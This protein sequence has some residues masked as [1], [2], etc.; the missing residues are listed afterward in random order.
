VYYEPL[1]LLGQ[2]D[3]GVMQMV[4][5]WKERNIAQSNHSMMMEALT[6]N[7]RDQLFDIMTS[8]DRKQFGLPT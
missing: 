2:V 3:G 5:A 7:E 1:A 4:E 6:A 8:M